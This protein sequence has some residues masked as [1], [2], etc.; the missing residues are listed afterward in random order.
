MP[1][2]SA[3]RVGKCALIH[4]YQTFRLVQ[5]TGRSVQYMSKGRNS[6]IVTTREWDNTQGIETIN[7]LVENFHR[8]T[9]SIRRDGVLYGTP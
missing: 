5:G 9:N 8:V 1:D 7:S 4:A 3:D 2:N 6:S